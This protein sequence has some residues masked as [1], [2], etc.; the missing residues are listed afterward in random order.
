MRSSEQLRDVLDALAEPE[1]LAVDGLARGS[2]REAAR[3]F[4]LGEPEVDRHR[5]NVSQGSNF[6]A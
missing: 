2:P 5:E 1:F 3:P 6:I 4:F